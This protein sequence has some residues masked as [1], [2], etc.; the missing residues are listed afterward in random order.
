MAKAWRGD[1]T[2]LCVY[3]PV[4]HAG[5]WELFQ[6]YPQVKTLL[7]M[8][9]EAMSGLFPVKKDLHG[10]SVAQM[11]ELLTAWGRFEV[12]E[13][14]SEDNLDVWRQAKFITADEEVERILQDWNIKP[15]QIK[16]EDVFLRWTRAKA[17]TEHEPQASQTVTTDDPKLLALMQRAEQAGQASRDFWRQ[18]GCILQLP[19]GSEI[20]TYNQHLPENETPRIVGDIRGQFHR[21][22]HW[23]LGSAIHAEAA[24]I[25]LAARA[26]KSTVGGQM[27]VTDFPCPNCAKL[28]V[29]AGIRTVFFR[30]GYAVA[31]GEDVLRAGDV[32]VIRVQTAGETKA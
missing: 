19:D 22:E 30:R 17:L 28:I 23:E 13:K 1:D 3:M 26:G 9:P 29:A 24:A 8:D 27:V 5:H 16:H 15:E 11:R 21:G 32:Q 2:V 20:V 4:L 6:R 31:D 25:G 14:L 18:V 12:V 10:L 7:L